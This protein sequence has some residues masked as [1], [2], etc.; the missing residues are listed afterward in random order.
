MIEK[1]II[2]SFPEKRR[3]NAPNY[4]NL[5]KTVY[6]KYAPIFFLREVH[7]IAKKG[8]NKPGW[9]AGVKTIRKV[10]QGNPR[11]IRQ[12]M[13]SLFDQARE[14][15]LTTRAQ[16]DVIYKFACDICECT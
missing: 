13:C 12:I 9:F 15:K 4:S 6:D 8:N 1:E 16:H 11:M 5:R 14:T 3:E 2:K 10:S 7:K